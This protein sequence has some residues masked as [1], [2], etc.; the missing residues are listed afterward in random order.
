LRVSIL[1]GQVTRDR[2]HFEYFVGRHRRQDMAVRE[3]GSI[4]ELLHIAMDST[5]ASVTKDL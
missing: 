1:R 4:T 3:S 2:V 5:G